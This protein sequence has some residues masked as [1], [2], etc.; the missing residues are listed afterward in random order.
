MARTGTDDTD[1]L[2]QEPVGPADD[3]EEDEHGDGGV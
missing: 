1:E 2:E 3:G